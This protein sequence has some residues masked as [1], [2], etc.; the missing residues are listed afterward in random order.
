MKHLRIFTTNSQTVQDIVNDINRMYP[1][2][3]GDSADGVVEIEITLH[4]EADTD[5][6]NELSN[7]ISSMKL[8]DFKDKIYFNRI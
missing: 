3:K 5:F 2:A 6:A 4:K 7:A 8:L 1:N